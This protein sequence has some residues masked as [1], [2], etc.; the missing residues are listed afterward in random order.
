MTFKFYITDTV[1]GSVCGTNDEGIAR[2]YAEN[3]E[4]FVVNAETGMWLMPD[5]R[6]EPVREA[7]D[8]RIEED[9]DEDED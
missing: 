3:E 9:E 7:D 1:D 4:N 6:E 8:N 2:D 5:D